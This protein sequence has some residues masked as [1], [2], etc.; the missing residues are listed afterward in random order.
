LDVTTIVF[1]NRKYAILEMELRNVGANPGQTAL[2][3]F[4]LKKPPV[5]WVALARGLGVEGASATSLE[6]LADLL[7]ASN[8]RKGPF[9]IEVV[10]G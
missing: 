4:D 3:L 9:L 10:V 1:S 8:R 5:D 2:D 6:Q 7:T